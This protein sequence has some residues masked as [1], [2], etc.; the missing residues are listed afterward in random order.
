MVITCF[1]TRVT[2]S[3]HGLELLILGPLEI[4]VGSDSIS[5]GGA[6]QRAVLA[7]LLLRAG[8][9]VSV[10]HL[11]EEIWGDVP[12]ASATHTLEVYVSRLR[13]LLNGHGPSLV[14]RG[15]GYVLVLGSAGSDATLFVELAAAASEAR[16]AS[17]AESASKLAREAV[18]IWRGRVAADVALGPAAA[19]DAQLLE[20]ARLR[21]LE[22]AVDADL[23]LGRHQALVGELQGL[24]A[25][26]P[27]RERFVVQLMLS[28]Y[29]CGRHVEA[30]DVYEQTRR[31]LDE[32]LGLQPSTEL[33]Q[34]AGQIVRQEAV[35]QGPADDRPDGAPSPARRRAGRLSGLVA[36]GAA[37]AAVTALTAAGSSR[38]HDTAAAVPR[39]R[40]ALVVQ[41]APAADSSAVLQQSQLTDALESMGPLAGAEPYV[42]E[43]ADDLRPADVERVA[44][45]LSAGGYQ[46]VLFAVG[47]D[48][49]RRF[50]RH[51][52]ELSRAR[53][54]FVDASLSELALRGSP[55]ATAIRYAT[56]GPA[57]LAGA[58]AGLVRPRAHS[59]GR[60]DV[61][62]VVAGRR[63]PE[64]VRVVSAFRRGVGRAIPD[65]RVLVDY[66]GEDTDPTACE[67]AANAQI[68]A[69]SDVVF[70]HS[71]LCGAGALAVARSRGVW[72]I[73][74]DG[75]GSSGGTVLASVFEDWDDAVY[76]AVGA[77]ADGTL[78]AGRDVVL[79]L[80]GYHVG[81]DMSPTLP[82]GIASKVV[83]LCSDVRLHSASSSIA[84]SDP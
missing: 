69:G 37:V 61:V 36:A 73:S 31:R 35:L 33:Q 62:S 45:R 53:V 13:Q 9:L 78:P 11:V 34:L 56:E 43:V 55:N 47:A 27:Y 21:T 23:D 49:A 16:E 59:S 39:P 83:R 41:R 44:G 40:V 42:L 24:V 29:R 4:R 65:A 52:R 6:K 80:D 2:N 1:A 10:E 57:Q 54:V 77:F 25:E 84:R 7:T 26:N 48:G 72:A 46:L 8:E 64:S 75:G 28:L 76:T 3:D 50:A 12:P 81:L 19:A 15:P 60:A 32:D 63:S 22:V 17:E 51:V 30:L 82:A 58:L 71:G 68:D 66:T 79:G 5:P 18:G 38:V 74:G 67:R 20:E 70:V 14:R